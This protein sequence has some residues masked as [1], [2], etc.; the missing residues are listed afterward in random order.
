MDRSSV[1]A[2]ARAS[3]NDASR[4]LRRLQLPASPAQ[5]V[6]QGVPQERTKRSRRA[7]ASGGVVRNQQNSRRRP[8]P[9]RNAAAFRSSM[10]RLANA[11]ATSAARRRGI[12]VGSRG[13]RSRAA[14]ASRPSKGLPMAAM[15]DRGPPPPTGRRRHSSG[16]ASAPI[17]R[18]RPMLPPANRR[19]RFMPRL[20]SAPTIAGF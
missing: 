20:T 6:W 15:G 19:R 4:L 1:R 2:T 18:A 11:R 7:S 13:V 5:P 12:A 3:V 9:R 16:R 8:D 14:S 10:R 17:N